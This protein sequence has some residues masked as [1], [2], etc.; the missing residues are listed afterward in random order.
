MTKAVCA[1]EWYCD[2]GATLGRLKQCTNAIEPFY[3]S[4]SIHR[5]LV[6][7]NPPSNYNLAHDSGIWA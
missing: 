3:E 6:D 2:Y 5:T 7:N 1:Q 4:I